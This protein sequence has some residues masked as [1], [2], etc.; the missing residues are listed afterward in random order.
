MVRATFEAY[1]AEDFDALFALLHP[2]VELHEWPEGP[3]SRAYRGPDSILRA[4]QEWAKAWEYIRAEPRGFV[5]ARD[6]VLVFIRSIGKGRGSSIEMELDTFGVYT[7]R[8]SK[9][10]KVEYFT[11]REAALAAA[12]VTEQQLRQEAT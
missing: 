2:D 8:D 9:V 3:D 12:G 7:I 5:E 4:R 6:R 11:D 10:S 1:Q